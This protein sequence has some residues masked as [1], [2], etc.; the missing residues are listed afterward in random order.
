MKKLLGLFL[1]VTLLGCVP[2]LELNVHTRHHF[3]E[4]N[5]AR[6]YTAPVWI[7]GRGVIL[8]EHYI[9]RQRRPIPGRRSRN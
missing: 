5:R 7:P 1:I 8:Q 2:T 9:P 4:L 6:F 3:Y